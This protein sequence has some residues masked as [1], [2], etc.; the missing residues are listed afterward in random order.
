[1]V[2]FDRESNKNL[3][4]NENKVEN[5]KKIDMLA[6]KMVLIPFLICCI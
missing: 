2:P 5:R 6:Y 3:C 4:D 1:M